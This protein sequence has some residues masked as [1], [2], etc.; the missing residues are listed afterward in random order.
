MLE[1]L[2]IFYI[3]AKKIFFGGLGE[4]FNEHFFGTPIGSIPIESEKIL[5]SGSTR[6]VLILKEVYSPLF[7]VAMR[8]PV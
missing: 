2:Q 5:A 7:F 8:T 4:T 3:F 1:P 6:G